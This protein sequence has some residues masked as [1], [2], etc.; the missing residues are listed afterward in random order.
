[1]AHLLY[2]SVYMGSSDEGGKTRLA[3]ATRS[4]AGGAGSHSGGK[5]SNG[6]SNEHNFTII[7]VAE[8]LQP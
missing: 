7:R 4:C 6:H 1:M 8:I 5:S 3:G 2:F